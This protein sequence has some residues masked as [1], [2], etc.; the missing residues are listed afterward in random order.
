MNRARTLIAED[1]PLSRAGLAEWVADTPALELVDT[2]ADG[3]SALAAVRTLRPA[4]VLMDIHMPGMTG[5]EVMRALAADSTAAPPAVIFTTAF[6]QHAVTA[7]EL[8]AV[9]YL[10]KP[11][12]RERFDE[13]VRHALS[14]AA[15]NASTAVPVLPALE[16]AAQA[17]GAEAAPLTR[18]MVRDQGRLFP[19]HVDAIEHLRSDTKYTAIASKGRSFLVRLP[20]TSFERRL[21]PARFLKISRSCIVNLDYVDS[22][23]P[24]DSSQFVVQMRDGTRVTASREVS[25]QL[26]ADSV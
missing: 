24:D 16:A 23:T 5:L 26:R 4:L 19:L 14:H 10:L 21:D 11:Y 13:A 18:I 8:H 20:I 2:V 3:T 25:K 9:D 12:A 7:F 1:E 6:D 17:D 15:A 22:M